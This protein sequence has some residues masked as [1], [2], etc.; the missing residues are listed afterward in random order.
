MTDLDKLAVLGTCYPTCR[1]RQSAMVDEA[2][3][4]AKSLGGWIFIHG[5]YRQVSAEERWREIYYQLETNHGK[6]YVWVSCP[7][8]GRDLPAPLMDALEGEDGG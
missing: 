7:F 4:P 2:F 1:E 6:P 8:C 5:P 3:L